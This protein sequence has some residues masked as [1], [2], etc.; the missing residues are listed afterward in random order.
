[1]RI[2][3]RT[4]DAYLAFQNMAEAMWLNA[5]DDGDTALLNAIDKIMHDN[6]RA[7]L[8]TSAGV[9]GG[10]YPITLPLDGDVETARAI[11][12]NCLDDDEAPSDEFIGVGNCVID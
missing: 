11:L 3:F 1:M 4:H 9:G 5:R 2:T 7:W 12:E 8:Q 10:G 6:N